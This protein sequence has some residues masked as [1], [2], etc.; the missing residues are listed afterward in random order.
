MQLCSRSYRKKHQWLHMCFAL[1]TS[2]SKP[3]TTTSAEKRIVTA[4]MGCLHLQR[5]KFRSGQV[6]AVLIYLIY[7]HLIY[8]D[9]LFTSYPWTLGRDFL[10]SGQMVGKWCLHCDLV[11]EPSEM[12]SL[13]ITVKARRKEMPLIIQRPELLNL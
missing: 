13:I 12:Y 6:H 4:A 5:A 11:S 7:T 9:T 1:Q 2:A 8:P 3:F 10:Y